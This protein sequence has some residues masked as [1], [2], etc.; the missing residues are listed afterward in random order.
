MLTILTCRHQFAWA[1]LMEAKGYGVQ[2]GS[3]LSELS[4]QD[5]V[6]AVEAGRKCKDSCRGLGLR[7]RQDRPSAVERLADLLSELMTKNSLAR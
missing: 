1:Q 4:V 6:Q 5:V 7:I 3:R 2:C